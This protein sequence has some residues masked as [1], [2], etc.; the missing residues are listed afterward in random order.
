M[1]AFIQLLELKF[2]AV[3]A[4]GSVKLKFH[5]SNTFNQLWELKFHAVKADIWL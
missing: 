4:D 2:H 1:E 3:K 5:L